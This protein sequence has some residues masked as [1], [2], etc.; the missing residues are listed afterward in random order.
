[1]ENY[2]NLCYPN[3]YIL[4]GGYSEFF[5]KHSHLCQPQGYIPMNHESFRDECKKATTKHNKQFKKCMSD[6]YL[7]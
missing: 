1:M 4:K 5:L 3:I 6:G 7:R 2:P